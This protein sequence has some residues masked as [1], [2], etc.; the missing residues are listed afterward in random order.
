MDVCTTL[1]L[2][3]GNKKPHR[4]KSPNGVSL[5]VKMEV[6]D[7]SVILIWF[8]SSY[9]E[10]NITIHRARLSSRSSVVGHNKKQPA[11]KKSTILIPPFVDETK[12]TI[13]SPSEMGCLV[14]I[15][16][17]IPRGRFV[18]GE[19]VSTEPGKFGSMTGQASGQGKSSVQ[20]EVPF[21]GR[22]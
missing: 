5:H 20:K 17:L 9:T 2:Q 19:D 8:H 21:G 1:M 7:S 15:V 3:D 6:F 11:R 4:Q 14:S 22:A 16:G 12:N 10:R 13:F 18:R